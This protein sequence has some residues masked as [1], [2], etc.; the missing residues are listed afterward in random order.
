MQRRLL[1]TIAIVIYV[2]IKD[3][4]KSAARNGNPTAVIGDVG[5]LSLAHLPP[6][7]Y[8]PHN[9]ISDYCARIGEYQYG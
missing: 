7:C 5:A 8:L 2:N 4:W 9:P 1:F 3:I 6:S